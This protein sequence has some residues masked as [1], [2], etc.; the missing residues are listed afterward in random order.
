VTESWAW[1]TVMKSL[2][3]SSIAGASLA[4]G[5]PVLAADMVMKTPPPAGFSW[6]GLYVGGNIGGLT[7]DTSGSVNPTSAAGTITPFPL[8]DISPRVLD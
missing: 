5:S 3:L 6:S 2:L 7:A 8:I 4:L 1:E